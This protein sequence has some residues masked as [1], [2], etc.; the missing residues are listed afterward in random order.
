MPLVTRGEVASGGKVQAGGKRN[1]RSEVYRPLAR[2]IIEVLSQCN[3]TTFYFS[4]ES[5]TS[6]VRSLYKI[7]ILI[8]KVI[9]KKL[10]KFKP[11]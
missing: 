3:T 8:M 1:P 10:L 7:A 2:E 9:I 4:S 11:G 5:Y 6:P